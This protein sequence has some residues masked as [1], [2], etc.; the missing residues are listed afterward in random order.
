M[1]LR[2]VQASELL[3]TFAIGDVHG[4]ADLLEP[5]L[6][7]I[8]SDARTDGIHYRI[9]FL[10]DIIDRGP[11]SFQAL[12]L[13][14]KTLDGVP[15]SVLILGNHE[16]FMLDFLTTG[17][18]YQDWLMN[19][20]PETL[21]SFGISPGTPRKEVATILREEHDD[22]VRMLRQAADAV[23]TENHI[24]VH[25]GLVPDLPLHAQHADD[26]RWIRD[27]FLESDFPSRKTVVHGHTPTDMC[28]PDLRNGRIAMD[29][30]AFASDVLSCVRI[31]EGEEPTFI[32]A[33]ATQ[34]L[35]K[36]DGWIDVGV[37]EFADGR[38]MTS[39]WR[40]WQDR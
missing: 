29:T 25:A 36:D 10:G 19:G 17:G 4:R 39:E 5:L 2:I 7:K 15:G 22:V 8:A 34:G 1:T 28:I 23:E 11:Q 9:I 38:S 31:S 3:T 16:E 24:F 35:T 30:G 18:S 32:R 6:A 27:V 20:G 26:L 33:M 21:R 40:K 14:Q 37:S 13:V 12:K